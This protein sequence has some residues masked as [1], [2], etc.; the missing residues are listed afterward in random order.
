MNRNLQDRL[1]EFTTTLLERQGAAVE[2]PPERETGLALLG[3]QTAAA[4]GC[5]EILPLS[6][7][8]EGALPVN[9]ATDFLERISPLLAGEPR[10]VRFVIP[11]LYL[12]Q[13]DMGE[14]VSRAFT[15]LNARV[16]VLR[17][18]ASRVEYHAWYFLA[19]LDSADRWQEIVPVCVNAQ[20]GA[21]IR[22]EDPLE[23]NVFQAGD[24]DPPPCPP[25]YS[26]AAC[27]A[28]GIVQSRA[29]SFVARMESQAQRDRKRLQEYYRALLRQGRDRTSRADH[30]PEKDAAKA[31]AVDLELKRKIAET[32]DRYAFRLDL[33][34]LALVRVDSP[35]LA[36]ECEVVR[37]KVRRTHLLFWN[38][39]TKELEPMRCQ[40][41]GTS[42]FAV[43]FSDDQVASLCADCAR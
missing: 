15:W 38:A 26:Q 24:D 39:M 9:L 35:V 37:R 28:A 10:V 16:K 30:A 29:A 34:P 7:G 41:C 19:T 6:F 33:T 3:A 40:S 31:R 25:T 5:L 1:R 43:A 8:A 27:H 22:M 13:A 21:M 17:A 4:L 11:E 12:K 18:Q 32:A 36:V 2:W 23:L 14:P 42:C 20:S